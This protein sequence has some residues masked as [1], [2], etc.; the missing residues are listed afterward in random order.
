M[1]NYDKQ[2]PIELI[3]LG[4]YFYDQAPLSPF[5]TPAW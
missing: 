2:M 1:L 4:L 3:Q 5:L